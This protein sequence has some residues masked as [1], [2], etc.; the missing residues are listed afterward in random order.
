MTSTSDS[1][2]SAAEGAG[3][4][5]WSVATAGTRT[6]AKWMIASLASAAA[7][8]FGAGAIVSRPALSWSSNSC[9]LLIA[10]AAGTI[11]LVSVILL[12]GLTATV[13][14]PVKIS[15]ESIPKEMRRDLDAAAAIRLPSDCRSYAEFLVNYPKY[16]ALATRL[17]AQLAGLDEANSHSSNQRAQLAALHKEAQHH[18]GVYTRAAESFLNQAEF[19]STSSKFRIHRRWTLALAIGA[20]LGALGFQLALAT[21]PTELPKEPELA[22]LVPPKGPSE[23]WSGLDLGACVVGGTVPVVVSGGKGTDGDPYA[24][25][26]L[27]TN[28][29][30]NPKSFNLRNDALTLERL[31][32]PTITVHYK[33]QPE[34]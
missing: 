8:I 25:T 24:V 22:Y 28:D 5:R 21:K 26:V 32:P 3:L 16:A 23:L 17:A 33:P 12:I 9:Q 29:R 14:T 20:S 30:C 15:L 18:V 11:G 13:L 2:A 19:Y 4:N 27:K 34:G 31:Q 6:A 1:G 7:L 10:L